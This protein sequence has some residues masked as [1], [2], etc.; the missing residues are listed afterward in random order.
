MYLNAIDIKKYVRQAI[1]QVW[2]IWCPSEVRAVEDPLLDMV[3]LAVRHCSSFVRGVSLARPI[4]PL[5]KPSLIGGTIDDM[6]ASA[7]AIGD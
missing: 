7:T 5:P 6:I 3:V 4:E 1:L 2:L